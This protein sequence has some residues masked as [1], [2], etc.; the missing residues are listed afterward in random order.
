MCG[1][2]VR[3][4]YKLMNQILKY[5]RARNTQESREE[6]QGRTTSSTEQ[7][8]NYNTQDCEELARERTEQWNKIQRRALNFD[9]EGGS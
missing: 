1:G 4:V 6:N 3:G 7:Q 2:G 5:R 8:K 9:K